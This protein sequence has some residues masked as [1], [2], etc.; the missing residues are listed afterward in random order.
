MTARGWYPA[1]A[2]IA[3]SEYAEVVGAAEGAVPFG[4][5]QNTVKRSWVGVVEDFLRKP[6]KTLT[7]VKDP[8]GPGYLSAYG[9]RP[10]LPSLWE[11]RLTSACLYF[12]SRTFSTEHPCSR[13]T[14]LELFAVDT[15]A[16]IVQ[17]TN[18][19]LPQSG[20]SGNSTRSLALF[21]SETWSTYPSLN[22]QYTPYPLKLWSKALGAP[23]GSG[24]CV[25][26]LFSPSGMFPVVP[27]QDYTTLL[28]LVEQSSPA[29]SLLP[30]W[31]GLVVIQPF[32]R[33][34]LLDRAGPLAMSSLACE[35]GDT[36]GQHPTPV[37]TVSGLAGGARAGGEDALY[38]S[39]LQST[40]Q[41]TRE[42][43][44][45]TGHLRNLLQLHLADKER[46]RRREERQRRPMAKERGRADLCRR[47]AEFC[48]SSSSRTSNL[49]FDSELTSP[50]RLAE[51]YRATVREAAKVSATD[52]EAFDWAL[53]AVLASKVAFEQSASKV[54][55]AGLRLLRQERADR[56]VPVV[57][58][59]R[60][61]E[62]LRV[63]S[64]HEENLCDGC[65]VERVRWTDLA[66]ENR[67][68]KETS[69]RTSGDLSRKLATPE[70][71]EECRQ[72]RKLLGLHNKCSDLTWE[73]AQ[74]ELE[75]DSLKRSFEQLDSE[76]SKL[77]EQVKAA[78]APDTPSPATPPAHHL[79]ERGDTP[80]PATPPAH[81]PAERGDLGER[82]GHFASV[83]YQLFS[84]PG[85][86][87]DQPAAPTPSLNR[88]PF[89]SP[90]SAGA[91]PPTA[92]VA[93]LQEIF[94]SSRVPK[95]RLRGT[96]VVRE[97]RALLNSYKTP[98]G[99][100]SFSGPCSSGYTS[101][102]C[103]PSPSPASGAPSRALA[104][105][106]LSSVLRPTKLG[107]FQQ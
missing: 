75:L 99:K 33:T 3:V 105:K 56:E 37:G 40:L 97:D 8:F 106:C 5:L 50:L 68:L 7:N 86:S 53:A 94:G 92:S 91:E 39:K 46:D 28:E 100:R 1:G 11:G 35:V 62:K 79:A 17:I 16:R 24:T 19:R 78:T 30:N 77:S 64:L 32:P 81:H 102:E 13:L 2:G 89:P 61:F 29:L 65:Q 73:C 47:V 27:R 88:G 96:Y 48:E 59:G 101:G 12:Y 76:K 54:V 22:A 21:P 90:A 70:L 45:D 66:E 10:G 43:I 63:S 6:W 58:Y 34:S 41:K 52:H 9:E 36:G 51:I 103:T 42:E 104:Q 15:V 26:D 25:G 31:N 4:D 83:R 67:Q 84:S 95:S 82:E 14:G 98:L 55:P 85:T 74:A 87:V 57:A 18:E 20:Q 71:E 60:K 72:L 23:E 107:R 80:T 69:T 38:L 93:S 44:S 49:D